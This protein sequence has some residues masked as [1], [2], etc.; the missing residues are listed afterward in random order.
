MISYLCLF[1]QKWRRGTLFTPC[2][3]LMYSTIRISGDNNDDSVV[4]L[5]TEEKKGWFD[6]SYHI[7]NSGSRSVTVQVVS[8]VTWIFEPWMCFMHCPLAES[9]R[10]WSLPDIVTM[11]NAFLFMTIL[12]IVTRNLRLF[13]VTQNVTRNFVSIFLIVCKSYILHFSI[14]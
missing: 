9:E 13:S 8:I 5:T 4:S 11:H 12:C 14:N 7:N 10:W 3:K 1:F 6:D 2:I